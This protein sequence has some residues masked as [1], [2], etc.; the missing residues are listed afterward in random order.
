VVRKFD[1]SSL[2]STAQNLTVNMAP[3]QS[4]VAATTNPNT[5]AI[6][7]GVNMT[8]TMA[9]GGNQTLYWDGLSSNGQALQS[10]T[11]LIELVRSET[12]QSSTVKTVA[13]SLLQ[14]KDLSA[15]DV[16]ASAKAAPDP[17]LKGESV[18][19]HYKPTAQ[20]WA[21]A[22]LYSQN[23]ELVGQCSDLNGSGILTFGRGVSGG[24]YVVDFEVHRNEAI[25]ARRILKVA[26]VR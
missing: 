7:G 4:A 22:R 8:L 26:V 14:S 21:V 24:I 2:S 15:E 10:G 11:Y 25:L 9:N 16:A 3:G 6:T 20:D 1:L 12:G 5:G 13:V 18:E 19:V 23:G 17:V